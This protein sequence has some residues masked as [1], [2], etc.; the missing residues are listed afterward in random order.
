MKKAEQVKFE[1]DQQE[2]K[3]LFKQFK[4]ITWLSD[5]LLEM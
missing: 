2:A 5:C 1:K 4:Q 3:N